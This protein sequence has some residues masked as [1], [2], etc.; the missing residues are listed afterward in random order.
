MVEEVVEGAMVRSKW[1]GGQEKLGRGKGG[2]GQEG[3]RQNKGERGR[4]TEKE[5]ERGREREP[6]SIKKTEGFGVMYPRIG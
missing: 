1:Q 2:S 3:G 6:R 5:R 4:R